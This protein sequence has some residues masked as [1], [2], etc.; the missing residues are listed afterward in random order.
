MSCSS[1]PLNSFFISAMYALLIGY[2]RGN[3]MDANWLTFGAVILGL[4][5][6]AVI[7]YKKGQQ[8]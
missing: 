4:A 2:E 1:W 3:V 7:V 5:V 6:A 8:P